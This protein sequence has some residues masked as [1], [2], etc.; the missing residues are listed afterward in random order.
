LGGMGSDCVVVT[1]IRAS[2]R[3]LWVGLGRSLSSQRNQGMLLMMGRAACE[4]TAE[5]ARAAWGLGVG[6]IRAGRREGAL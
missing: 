2:R 3:V 5:V 1:G 6:V 4:M